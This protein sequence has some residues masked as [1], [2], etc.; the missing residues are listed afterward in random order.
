MSTTIPAQAGAPAADTRAPQQVERLPRLVQLV[1]PA[2]LALG[3]VLATTGMSL[4]LGAMEE[5]ARL[6]Q[7]MFDDSNWTASHLM[8]G[9][10]FALVAIGLTHAVG[11]VRGRGAVPVGVGAVLMALG[12]V[13]MALGDI[14]HGALNIAL[15]GQVDAAQSLDIHTSY[16][17]QA[18]VA[19]LNGGSGLLPLG[20]IILGIGLLWSRSVPRWAGIVV[21]LTPFAVKASFAPSLPS[22]LQGLP[23]LVG[24]LVLTWLM[25]QAAAQRR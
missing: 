6:A 12:A 22:Y 11:L 10:G 20:M 21:L 4:H 13:L 7:A 8:L 19:G 25:V 17:E 14:S 15:R 24:M 5:D 1:G 23:F 9:I 16:F 3:A 18:S 2:A